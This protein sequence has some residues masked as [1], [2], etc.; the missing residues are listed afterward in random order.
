MR[1]PIWILAGATALIAAAPLAAQEN[2]AAPVNA[3]NETT[4]VD[5]NAVMD[6]NLVAPPP[7]D[8]VE[9]AVTPTDSELA[10]EVAADDD[11]RRGF[12]WGLLGIIGLIGLL[13]RRRS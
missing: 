5:A 9:P 12:P 1:N 13:G 6:A 3:T 7:A 11:E 8:V 10:R 4:A 2:V